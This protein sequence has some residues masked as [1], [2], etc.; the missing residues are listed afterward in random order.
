MRGGTYKLTSFKTGIDLRV[1]PV[2][3]QFED[4]YRRCGIFPGWRNERVERLRQ[5]LNCSIQDLLAL[6]AEFDFDVAKKAAEKDRWPPY[7]SLHFTL[8]EAALAKKEAKR[9]RHRIMRPEFLTHPD[10]GSPSH[11]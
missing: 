2:T 11:S 1:T 8:L 5:R 6:C 4:L 9:R 3:I 10:H 7:L